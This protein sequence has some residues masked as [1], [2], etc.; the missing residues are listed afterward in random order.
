MTELES[1]EA[2]ESESPGSSLKQLLE[3]LGEEAKEFTRRRPLEGL[4]LSFV[5][6][7]NLSDLLGRGR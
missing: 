7:M 2:A 4:L 6:G 1:D 5:A 3:S